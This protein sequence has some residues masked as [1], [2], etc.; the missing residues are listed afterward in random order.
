MIY[1]AQI[2]LFLYVKGPINSMDKISKDRLGFTE[3][4]GISF[5]HK[6]CPIL[7]GID[8]LLRATRP[9]GL[10]SSNLCVGL[11]LWVPAGTQNLF[12]W[13]LSP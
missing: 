12:T 13:A 11:S 7:C 4:R 1:L 3:I 5:F 9:L 10:G 2:L 6:G 8:P